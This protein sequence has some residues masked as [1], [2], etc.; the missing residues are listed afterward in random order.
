MQ[1]LIITHS[2]FANF[3]RQ[4]R[5]NLINS[6]SGYKPA[7]LI[8]TQNK[9]QQSNLAIFSS[10]VHL[11]ANP[12]L[13]GFIQRPLGKSGHTYHN[14][15]ESGC[16]TINH[17]HESFIEQAHYTSAN[18]DSTES[19]FSACNFTEE[20]LHNFPAPFVQQSHIKIAMELVEEVFITHNNTRF[21][22]GAIKFIV[23]PPQILAINGSLNLSGVKDVCISGLENYHR[24][25][26]INS[27]PYAKPDELPKW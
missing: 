15:K 12:A 6:V 4:Y 7:M 27:L 17:V 5:A 8:G 14:I 21:I 2:D 25:S 9:Q 24:V 19:E 23:V 3:G 16:Y 13:L 18:F 20:Y 10:L 22:I 1:P 26:P 11:G